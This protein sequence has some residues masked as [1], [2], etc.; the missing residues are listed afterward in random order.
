ME[1]AER[2]R[3]LH[4]QSGLKTVAEMVD[5]MVTEAIEVAEADVD[6]V[7]GGAALMDRLDE[8]SR[9]DLHRW[10][11]AAAQGHDA[12]VVLRSVGGEPEPRIEAVYHG[13]LSREQRQVLGR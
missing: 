11:Q 7:I 10:L 12:W 1:A 8:Q 4:V 13:R 9:G 5:E 2:L 3:L 6:I